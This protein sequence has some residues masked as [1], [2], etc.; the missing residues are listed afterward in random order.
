MQL[1]R[2]ASAIATAGARRVATPRPAA[3]LRPRIFAAAT[4]S[5]SSSYVAAQKHSFSS[6]ARLDTPLAPPVNLPK[7]YVSSQNTTN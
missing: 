6:S 3:A 1:L 7:W 4:A 2:P 5:S